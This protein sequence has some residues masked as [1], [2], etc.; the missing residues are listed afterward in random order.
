MDP[1]LVE[2]N[3][4]PTKKEVIVMDE[5]DVIKWTVEAIQSQLQSSTT[6]NLNSNPL[7]SPVISLKNSTSH[8]S[9]DKDT[10]E[11][12][13]TPRKSVK[14]Y[15]LIHTDPQ[16]RHIQTTPSKHLPPQPREPSPDS[17][18]LQPNQLTSIK[19]LSQEFINHVDPG[20]VY[21]EINLM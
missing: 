18:D 1:N 19:E 15:N 8:E 2:V 9:G 10:F 12:H 6:T 20:I 14:P 5:E 21:Y 3:V 13:Y 7:P 17:T 4:H 11:S 16:T